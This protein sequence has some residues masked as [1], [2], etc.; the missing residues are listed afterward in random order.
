[1]T[2]W[3]PW[4]F[5]DESLRPVYLVAL[6]LLLILWYYLRVL[7]RLA[8]TTLVVL[9]FLFMGKT[10][11]RNWQAVPFA[12]LRFEPWLLMASYV[13][14]LVCFYLGVLGWKLI[15]GKLG[16]GISFPA[17]TRIYSTSQFGKYMPGKV[18]FA[19]GRME[20]ARAEGVPEKI[21][22]ISVVLESAFLSVASIVLFLVCLPFYPTH[23]AALRYASVVLLP[24]GLVLLYPPLFNRILNFLLVRFKRQPVKLAMNYLDVLVLLALYIVLWV[25]QTLAMY[26]LVRSFYPADANLLPVLI[27]GYAIS[28]MAGFLVL[29]APGGLGVREG[30][31][32]AMLTVY[33]RDP[34]PGPMATIIPVVSRLWITAGEVVFFLLSLAWVRVWRRN[35][36]GQTARVQEAG[37][38]EA[39]GRPGIH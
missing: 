17:A 20:L 11:Y 13:L 22:G 28:W 7:R 31:F 21:T 30:I 16:S 18:W 34:R 1:L 19:L 9:I 27:G 12:N 39:G 38:G 37:T 29:L 35:V 23:V 3:L 8:G 14:L 36:K 4:P 32:Y 6:S 10:L 26:L 2:A 25:G 24:A 33:F 15:L 5:A